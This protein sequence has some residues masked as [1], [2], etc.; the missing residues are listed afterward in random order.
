M[1]E[2]TDNDVES[3][4]EVA[5][6]HEGIEE[7][8]SIEPLMKSDDNEGVSLELVIWLEMETLEESV[9]N[10]FKLEVG[11]TGNDDDNFETWSLEDSSMLELI[12]LVFSE[13]LE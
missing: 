7:L 9:D 6:E 11:T 1:I 2:D 10:S 12:T 4:E 5:W 8:T 3:I 13:T